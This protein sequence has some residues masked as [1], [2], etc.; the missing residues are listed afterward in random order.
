MLNREKASWE[1]QAKYNTIQYNTIRKGEKASWE[2][3]AK[4]EYNAK[5][6]KGFMGILG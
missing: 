2:Y 6:G 5:R 4:R 1:Y 3:Q